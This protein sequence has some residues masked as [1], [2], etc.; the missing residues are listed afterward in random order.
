MTLFSDLVQV[1]RKARGQAS[2]S[3]SMATIKDTQNTVL[4]TMAAK[5]I[6]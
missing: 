4:G 5:G 2:L 6:L 1:R 3:F